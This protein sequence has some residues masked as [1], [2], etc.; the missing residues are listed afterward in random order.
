MLESWLVTRGRAVRH[1]TIKHLKTWSDNLEEGE[2]APLSSGIIPKIF[3]PCQAGVL[4]YCTW[5]SYVDFNTADLDSSTRA[6][7]AYLKT[8]TITECGSVF[9]EADLAAL[10]ALSQLQTLCISIAAQVHPYSVAPLSSLTAL[11]SLSLAVEP[12]DRM[13]YAN[14]TEYHGVPISLMSLSALTSLSLSG[15]TYLGHLPAAIGS[16]TNLRELQICDSVLTSLPA[17]L[18]QLSLL[19]IIDFTSNALGRYARSY[20]GTQAGSY[21]LSLSLLY[22][23]T[24]ALYKPVK[25]CHAIPSVYKRIYYA[26]EAVC[27]LHLFRLYMSRAW[28]LDWEADGCSAFSAAP[29]DATLL[30]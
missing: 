15:W 30:L 5:N 24:K 29:L 20:L 17:G 1:L 22:P 7:Q 21:Q 16:L 25:G 9:A 26:P 14:I 23:I 10:A 18:A 28:P 13:D 19:E 11:N 3:T 4:V 8:L 2:I 27:L 6:L 12:G